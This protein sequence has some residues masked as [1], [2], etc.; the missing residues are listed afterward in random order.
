MMRA[1]QYLLCV[2]ALLPLFHAGAGDIAAGNAQ[3]GS[4]GGKSAIFAKV[5]D[6]LITEQEYLEAYST[7]ARGKFYHGKP[8]EG[9]IAKLQREVGQKLVARVLL[10]RE[11]E[12]RALRPDSAETGKALQAYEQRYANSAQ[13]KQNRAQVLPALTARLEQDNLLSQLEKTVRAEVKVAEGDVRAYYLKHSEKF[14]EPEQLRVSVILLKVAPSAPVAVWEK[15]NDEAVSLLARLRGGADFA[16]LAREYS[17]DPT[18][19]QGGDM[20]YLHAGMV[21]AGT[22]AELAKLQPGETSDVLR[23]LEGVAV[24]RLVDRKAARL[25]EF[26]AVKKR[27]QEL[28]QK[29]RADAA[30]LSFVAE[31]AAKTP[32]EM[33]QS[34]FLPLAEQ[35]NVSGTVN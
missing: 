31:L 8:P 6:T 24:L 2:A 1:K 26:D 4:A 18:G 28:V 25:M 23:L 3:A 22:E 16:A 27:A 34:H 12:R 7:A 15:A 30:W 13:W 5:G 19:E 17:M 14:T 9:E 20:G 21:P 35:S 10:L 11:A 33:D 32:A 29:E